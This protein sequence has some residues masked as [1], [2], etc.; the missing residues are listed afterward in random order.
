MQ[1]TTNLCTRLLTD[2]QTQTHRMFAEPDVE[3]YE[4]SHLYWASGVAKHIVNTSQ[5]LQWE[6]SRAS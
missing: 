6:S 4:V 3:S 1:E 2:S 5:C